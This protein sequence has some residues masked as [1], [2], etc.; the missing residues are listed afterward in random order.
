MKVYEV[1][2][3]CASRN[4]TNLGLDAEGLGRVDNSEP[5]KEFFSSPLVP[6]PAQPS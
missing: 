1:R 6:E 5:G 2:I 3:T 4:Q